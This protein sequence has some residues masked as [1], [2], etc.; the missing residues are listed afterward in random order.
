MVLRANGSINRAIHYNQADGGPEHRVR[1]GSV[2]VANICIFCETQC[3]MLAV[4]NTC[5]YQ[6]FTSPAERVMPVLNVAWSN[7]SLCR[8]EMPN[9][10]DEAYIRSCCSMKEL[11]KKVNDDVVLKKAVMDN[12][13]RHDGCLNTADRIWGLKHGKR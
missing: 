8:S 6:S 7:L 12:V 5:P 4:M 2:K 13:K 11:R 3:D 10:Q 1:N 9:P